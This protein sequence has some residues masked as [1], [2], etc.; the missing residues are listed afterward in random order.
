[1]ALVMPRTGRR[2]YIL[3]VCVEACHQKGNLDE[4]DVHAH[5]AAQ[6]SSRLTLIDHPP[7]RIVVDT[8]G[9]FDLGVCARIAYS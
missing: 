4:I 2:A 9:I 6:L 7:Q 3:I 8:G 5:R 1:M